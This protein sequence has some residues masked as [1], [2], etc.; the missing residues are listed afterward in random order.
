MQTKVLSLFQPLCEALAFSR[1]KKK[2]LQA[3]KEAP[4]PPP[5]VLSNLNLPPRHALAP[6]LSEGFVFFSVADQWS[7]VHPGQ[8]HHLIQKQPDVL[9]IEANAH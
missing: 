9:I 8:M 2:C 1:R 7:L 5:A 6:V 3:A 4:P